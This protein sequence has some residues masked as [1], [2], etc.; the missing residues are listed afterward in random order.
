MTLYDLLRKLVAGGAWAE[1]EKRDAE[2]LIG[3][4]EDR[5]AFGN[6]TAETNIETERK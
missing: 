2:N 6:T 1:S 5:A 4:L 3:E